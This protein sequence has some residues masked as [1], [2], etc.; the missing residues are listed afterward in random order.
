M[1]V[2]LIAEGSIRLRELVALFYQS[3]TKRL[4]HNAKDLLTRSASR[5]TRERCIH[6]RKVIRY[7]DSRQNRTDE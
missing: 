2:S 6:G 1:R 7:T 5:A 4:K 3:E